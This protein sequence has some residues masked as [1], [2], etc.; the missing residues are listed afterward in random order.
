MR[1][2]ASYTLSASLWRAHWSVI[3]YI[4]F[5]CLPLRLTMTLYAFCQS[6]CTKIH[7]WK[8][9]RSRGDWNMD[10]TPP[11][12]TVQPY[13]HANELI[14]WWVRSIWALTGKG[15]HVRPFSL[16]TSRKEK[17]TDSSQLSQFC[18]NFHNSK[19]WQSPKTS[20]WRKYNASSVHTSAVH[21]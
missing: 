20:Q 11:R 18:K 10:L 9:K 4:S 6:W 19:V 15:V 21:L 1:M 16:T 12:I 14:F 8:R 17:Q 3:S 5:K 7:K 13:V 2:D